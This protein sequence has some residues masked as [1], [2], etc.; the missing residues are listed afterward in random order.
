MRAGQRRPSKKPRVNKPNSSTPNI[1]CNQIAK[2][3]PEIEHEITYL[4]IKTILDK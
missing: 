4:K 1:H 2:N 3:I